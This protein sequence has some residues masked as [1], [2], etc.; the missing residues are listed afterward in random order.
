MSVA[1]SNAVSHSPRS[2]RLPMSIIVQPTSRTIDS[3]ATPDRVSM[4]ASVWA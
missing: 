1:C 4:P 2:I 3:L